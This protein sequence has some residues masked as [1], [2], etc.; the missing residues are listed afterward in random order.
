LKKI[1]II[2]YFYPPANFVGAQR[3]AAW[4]KY[5]HEF[6]YYPIIITRQ[7]NNGQTDLIDQQENNKL[8]IDYNKTHEVHRLPYKRILRDKLSN[9]PWLKPFQKALTLKEMIFSNWSIKSLSFT[10]FYKHSKQLLQDNPD[11]KIV[12]ASGRPFQAFSF[13]HQ[14]KV[15]FPSIHW[16]PDYRDEWST[17]RVL[18]QNSYLE[19]YLYKLNKKSEKKWT[20]NSSKFITVSNL[21]RDSISDFI[22]KPGL[23][24]TNGYDGELSVDHYNGVIKTE[25]L[26]L[27]YIGTVYS[28]QDFSILLNA[29]RY[30]ND[31]TE[32]PIIKFTFLGSYSN[33]GEKLVLQNKL[34]LLG[35][36]VFLIDKVS[37]ELVKGYIKKND[38]LILTEYINLQG[39][40]P[41]KIFD[42]YNSSKPILLCPSDNDLME[43]FIQHTSSGYI[44][45]TQDECVTIL[46]SMIQMKS[47]GSPL[48]GP[49]N[50]E[51]AIFYSR[52]YQ[53]TLLAKELDKLIK[54]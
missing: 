29:I 5:L 9:F 38:V 31:L 2:S 18:K 15:D 37:K 50:T 41:V 24:I 47:L 46:N 10:N 20:K 43:R 7:W 12:I 54:L 1:L 36:H 21:W 25:P 48:I 39:C 51:K 11:I 35:Q 22:N 6:G 23:V 27:L 45:N 44:A 8:A 3:T 4:A 28:H 52:S 53:T 30:I 34:R 19:K 33:D 17:N 40:L 42:Y 16:I 14:L 32:T 13:G 49:R 26:N